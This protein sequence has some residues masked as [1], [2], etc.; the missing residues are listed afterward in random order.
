M[1]GQ[2]EAAAV[3]RVNGE[4]L[5][6]ARLQVAGSEALVS[7]NAVTVGAFAQLRAVQDADAE[8]ASLIARYNEAL[9]RIG[10]CAADS[11]A[12]VAKLAEGSS[13][14]AKNAAAAMASAAGSV[15][16]AARAVDEYV[17]EIAGLAELVSNEA[18]DTGVSSQA[19]QV[20]K[21]ARQI[22]QTSDSLRQQSLEA[23]V[24]SATA[25]ATAA[26]QSALDSTQKI[27][28]LATRA[29]S[30]F[31]AAAAHR[32][33]LLRRAADA[34]SAANQ[35]MEAYVASALSAAGSRAMVERLS[36][37]SNWGLSVSQVSGATIGVHANVSVI[38]AEHDGR[39]EPSGFYF[40][41]VPSRMRYGFQLAHAKQLAESPGS[42]DKPKCVQT[43]GKKS[44]ADLYFT[45][46]GYPLSSCD[47]GYVAFALAYSDSPA[48]C[49]EADLSLASDLIYPVQMLP[50]LTLTALDPSNSGSTQPP[51]AAN[52]TEPLPLW[53]SVQAAFDT[54]P[55]YTGQLDLR[56]YL[57]R[58]DV[59]HAL[60]SAA[61]STV[62]LQPDTFAQRPVQTDANAETA[63]PWKFNFQQGALDAFGDLL[64]AADHYVAIA[65]ASGE[66]TQS[67]EDIEKGVRPPLDVQTAEAILELAPV[68][69]P[70]EA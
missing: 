37:V 33:D 50:T 36:S 38:H 21:Q 64:Q 46:E 27:K 18:R 16:T 14:Y 58:W 55:A 34:S 54:A 24:L 62:F 65:Y 69:S 28:D 23:N 60:G 56:C 41:L 53:F 1:S 15:K 68:A 59:Y 3:R 67:S 11:V 10:A 9:F 52:G 31:E 45:I 47:K 70:L 22:A 26:Q 7:Q 4:V 29:E 2:D 12:S 40:F 61:A 17:R 49:T 44:S 51:S 39:R 25:R 42:A 35:A 48:N 8:F 63:G 30:A 6:G 5:E 66:D 20:L 43:K 13:T 57:V 32:T 19:K